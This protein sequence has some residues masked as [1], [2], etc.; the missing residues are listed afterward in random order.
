MPLFSRSLF[1]APHA[2]APDFFRFRVMLSTRFCSADVSCGMGA[3]DK[4]VN[5]KS[6]E[7]RAGSEPEKS[8]A[9]GPTYPRT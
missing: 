4:A 3:S 2:S 1:T 6:K 5:G 9:D 7:Q 8:S